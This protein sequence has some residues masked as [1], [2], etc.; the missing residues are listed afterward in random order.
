MADELEFPML[1]P[2]AAIPD[3]ASQIDE[4]TITADGAFGTATFI[5]TNAVYRAWDTGGALPAPEPGTFEIR[6]GS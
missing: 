5:E 3:G 6:C 1:M 2:L 4:V